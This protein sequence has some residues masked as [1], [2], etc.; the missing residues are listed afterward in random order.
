M[1]L[2]LMKTRLL[3]LSEPL[4]SLVPERLSFSYWSFELDWTCFIWFSTLHRYAPAACETASEGAQSRR[5]WDRMRQS[6][7][8]QP[9][10]KLPG[11]KTSKFAKN[12]NIETQ[13]KMIKSCVFSRVKGLCYPNCLNWKRM[14]IKS[15]KAFRLLTKNKSARPHKVNSLLLVL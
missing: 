2:S 4:C 1:E 9:P 12:N 14:R 3:Q 13:L 10:L 11:S 15:L 6:K 5:S 7:I 8:F